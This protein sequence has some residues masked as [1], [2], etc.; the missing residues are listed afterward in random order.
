M[1]GAHFPIRALPQTPFLGT[2]ISYP[3]DS[4]GLQIPRDL[5]NH[6]NS[7]EK[8]GIPANSDRGSSWIVKLSF[9]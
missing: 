2:Q 6:R 5:E 8:A 3:T 4:Q 1:T 7:C 9:V